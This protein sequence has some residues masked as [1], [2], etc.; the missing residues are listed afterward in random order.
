[1]ANKACPF[2]LGKVNLKGRD[3]TVDEK[4]WLVNR[5]LSKKA[6]VALLVKKYNLNKNTLKGWVTKVNNGEELRATSGRPVAVDASIKL[7]VLD[8]IKCDPYSTAQ[9]EFKE[10][11]H[12]SMQDAALERGI[13]PASVYAPSRS[14]LTRL[15]EE[16]KLQP[17][18]GEYTTE[19]R[20]KATASVRNAVSFAAMSKWAY[21]KLDVHPARLLNGDGTSYT[22]GYE[23]SGQVKILRIER[24]TEEEVQEQL[25]QVV[26]KKG[27]KTFGLYTVKFYFVINAY[28]WTFD[29]IFVIQDE[30][31]DADDMDWYPVVGLGVGT[32]VTS[33]GYIVFMTSRCGNTKFYSWLITHHM[34]QVTDKINEV[35][36]DDEKA[37]DGSFFFKL[38]GEPIQLSPFA[39]QEIHEVLEERKIF[40]G[41]SAHSCTAI[42]QEC[43]AGKIILGT[44]KTNSKV[45]DRHIFNEPLEA[46]ITKVFKEHNAKMNNPTPQ[47]ES[48]TSSDVK[49]KPKKQKPKGISDYH[50]K[51]GVKGILRVQLS[52][53]MTLRP[54]TIRES[55]HLVGSCPFD[56]SNIL[57]QLR[58]KQKLSTEERNNITAALPELVALFDK[59]GELFEKDFDKFK[60]RKDTAA[61]T[62][63]PRD[64]R[65]LHQR[66]CVLLTHKSVR[67]KEF[68]KAIKKAERA[69]NS[70]ER[71]RKIEAGELPAPKKRVSKKK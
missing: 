11:V 19:A 37:A 58:I 9:S 68:A 6:S 20:A 21:D 22:V 46:A 5:V 59:Q 35:L 36:K 26:P 38:D 25:K 16:M 30:T 50:L 7:S 32:D 33:K 2:G 8:T 34:V 42:Q 27:A 55:F 57:K 10:V 67:E 62:S 47:P 69:A 31:M 18:V 66:R 23:S 65:V 29:P 51:L 39:E 28:G 70:A 45:N 12:K 44:K 63:M 43:D 1:M 13:N 15:K 3:L 24:E 64:Q 52:I 54:H 60:I 4:Y 53:Q 48:S 14:T 17:E 61:A 40:T 49:S 71:K 41:K 56:L